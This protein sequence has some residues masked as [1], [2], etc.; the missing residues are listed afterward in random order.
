MGETRIQK[1]IQS[2]KDFTYQPR[3]ARRE[4]IAKKNSDK[5]RPLGIPAPNDK[6]VQEI[7]RMILESSLL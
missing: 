5:K 1:I 4:Y 2:L 6:L 3:P 7:V